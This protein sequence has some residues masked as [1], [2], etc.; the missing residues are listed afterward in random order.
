M[1]AISGVGQ[2]KLQQYGET[3]VGLVQAYCQ[4]HGIQEKRKKEQKRQGQKEQEKRKEIKGAGEVGMR[5]TLVAEAY[6]AG[7]SLPELMQRYAVTAGTILDHLARYL[8]AGNALRP[9]EDTLAL[10]TS[11]P[12]Q[13]AAAFAA[14]DELG[15]DF[16]RPVFDKLNGALDYDELKLLRLCYLTQE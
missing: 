11:S 9:G 14:F 8:A 16:L 7:E 6:N 13:Q 15:T 5:T 2:V 12:E 10:S 1:H 3:F 4:S